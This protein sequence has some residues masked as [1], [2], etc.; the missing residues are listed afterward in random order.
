MEKVHIALVGGQP[1]PVYIGIKDDTSTQKVV[2]ICSEQSKD[3]ANRIRN[4]FPNLKFDLKSISPVDLEQIATIFQQL[5]KEYEGYE[6]TINLSGGTKLWA[7]SS[8]QAFVDVPY[9]HFL[10]VDQ[11]N[12]IM[13]IKT[14]LIHKGSIDMF[15]R[16]KL[17]D[18][19]LSSHR[20]LEDFK[21]NDFNVVEKIIQLRK[22]F[23]GEINE[24]TRLEPG[25]RKDGVRF[26]RRGSSMSFSKNPSTAIFNLAINKGRKTSS[27]SLQ[28]E[29]L[30]KFLFN[31]AW[32]ELKV[33]HDISRS[34]HVKRVVMNC[35][36]T[37]AKGRSKNEIDI[38]AEL[39]DRLLFVECKT[40]IR[41]N[42]DLDK[43]RSAVRNFSGIS[44]NA[45]F[46]TLDHPGNNYSDV[47]EKCENNGITT[48]NYSLSQK[49]NTNP[50][51]EDIINGFISTQNKR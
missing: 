16:F 49:D 33:A 20:K 27:F 22:K 47:L 8:H 25:M 14:R 5:K 36:F 30:E 46:V 51:L 39:P 48:F 43:F 12:N 31:A 18:A 50:S 29:N 32:F 45:L 42:T 34:K 23:P 17:Y 7:L 44:S 9:V 15:T 2:L 38:I 1:I 19:T 10:Y 4:Q 13:D 37:Y 24:L 21:E 28:S 35:E 40:M 6:I 26:S 41:N 3:E 11:T